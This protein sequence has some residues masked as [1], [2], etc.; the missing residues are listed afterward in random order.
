V[1]KFEF[2]K[3]ISMVRQSGGNKIAGAYYEKQMGGG[4]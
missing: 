2:L 1:K 3:T 4:G